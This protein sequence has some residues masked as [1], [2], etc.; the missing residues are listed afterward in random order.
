MAEVKIIDIDGI[1][2]S[3]K[4]ETARNKITDIEKNIS[5]ED[6]PNAIITIKE[7]YTCKLIQIDNHYKVGKIHFAVVRIDR[8]SG[9]YVGTDGTIQIAYTNLIPKKNTNFILRD[10][11]TGMMIRCSLETD[12]SIYIN[13]SNGINNDTNILRGEII[14]AEP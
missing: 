10:S 8:L 12:G 3:M 9:E 6:L 1:Q 4:D 14:F 11:V 2:W 13:E 5:T 7:G